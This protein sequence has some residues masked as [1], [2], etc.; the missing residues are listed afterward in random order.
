MELRLSA[1]VAVVVEAQMAVGKAA[2][3]MLALQERPI[4]AAAAEEGHIPAEPALLAG[5]ASSL[6]AIPTH[7]RQPRQ[8]P[9]HRQ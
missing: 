7:I 1:Q 6:F 3:E 8:R 2:G 9:D 5:Q 4:Q